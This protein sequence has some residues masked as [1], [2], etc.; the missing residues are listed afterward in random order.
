MSDMA[1][2]AWQ[3]R[4]S[5]P[6]A[7]GIGLR[8]VH[9]DEIIERRPAINWLEAHTENYF[10]AGGAQLQA[11]GRIREDYPLLSSRQYRRQM[12][13]ERMIEQGGAYA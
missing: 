6:A 8:A 3:A 9:Q 12:E 10:A 7:A 13:Q 2:M 4:G 1:S 5:I 11:L